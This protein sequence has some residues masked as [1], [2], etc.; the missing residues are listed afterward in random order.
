MGILLVIVLSVALGFLLGLWVYRG[1]SAGDTPAWL[2]AT[3]AWVRAHDTLA[4]G[5]F[6]AFLLSVS[7]LMSGLKRLYAY[8]LL[9]VIIAAGGYLLGAPLWQTIVFLGAMISLSGVI[10]LNRFLG[11]YPVETS[12]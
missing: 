12:G 9:T 8:A 10:L 7:A 2:L 6:G 5:L 1:Q 4:F 3:V 11:R